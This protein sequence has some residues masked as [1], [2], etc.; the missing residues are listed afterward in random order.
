M[1]ACLF[2]KTA[3]QGQLPYNPKFEKVELTHLCFADD[4][5]FASG[6]GQVL[7]VIT[8]ILD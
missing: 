4:F 8:S 7:Q 2:N 6:F 1:F 3:A 5:V